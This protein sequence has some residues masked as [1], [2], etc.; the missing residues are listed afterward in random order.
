ML[1]TYR[2]RGPLRLLQ[3]GRITFREIFESPAFYFQLLGS[4]TNAAYAVGLASVSFVVRFTM[5]TATAAPTKQITLDLT[6]LQQQ[7]EDR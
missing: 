4:L 6:G 7:G 5:Y 2:C 3:Y 1:V